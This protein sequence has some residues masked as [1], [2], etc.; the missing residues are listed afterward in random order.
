MP[1]RILFVPPLIPWAMYVG[2]F[3]MFYSSFSGTN[4]VTNELHMPDLYVVIGL[5]IAYVMF[6]VFNLVAAAAERWI[7]TKRWVGTALAI[8]LLGVILAAPGLSRPYAVAFGIGVSTAIFVPMA[9]MRM[10]LASWGN[11][12]RLGL[13]ET[14]Q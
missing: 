1:L 2:L 3:V 8:L 6:F 11:T 10:L 9:L 13:R 7:F 14:P 5:L 4:A 12:R